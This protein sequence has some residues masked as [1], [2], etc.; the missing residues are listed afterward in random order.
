MLSQWQLNFNMNI[1]GELQTI[2]GAIIFIENLLLEFKPS[3]SQMQQ[4]STFLKETLKLMCN[5][6]AQV[7]EIPN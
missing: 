7:V 2:A 4:R 5:D 1:L 3:S 6:V